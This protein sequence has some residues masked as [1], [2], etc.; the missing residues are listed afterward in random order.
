MDG[1][2]DSINSHPLRTGKYAD[3]KRYFVYFAPD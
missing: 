1:D 3:Y 2:D